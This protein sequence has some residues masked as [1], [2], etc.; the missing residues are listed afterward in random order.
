MTIPIDSALQDFHTCGLMAPAHAHQANPLPTTS[1]PCSSPHFFHDPPGLYWDSETEGLK[2]NKAELSSI[3]VS[4]FCS[5]WS[6]SFS[7]DFLKMMYVTMGT[8][9]PFSF[10]QSVVLEGKCKIRFERTHRDPGLERLLLLVTT[11]GSCR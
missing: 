8:A 6:L 9:A 1:L 7:F 4:S 10:P 11:Q 2:P 3:A 5:N